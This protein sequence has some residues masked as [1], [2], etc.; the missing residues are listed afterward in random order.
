MLVAGVEHVCIIYDDD[1]GRGLTLC[2][3][4]IGPQDIGPRLDEEITCEKCLQV[5]AQGHPT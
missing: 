2:E 5:E 4:R 3:E 1:T